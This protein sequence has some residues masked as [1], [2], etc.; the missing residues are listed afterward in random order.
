M[1]NIF[2]SVKLLFAAVG[3]LLL[4][5]PVSAQEWE[6]I[7]PMDTLPVT[8]PWRARDAVLDFSEIRQDPEVPTNNVLYIDDHSDEYRRGSFRYDWRLNTELGV[9]ADEGNEVAGITMVFRAKPTT[10]SIVNHPDSSNWWWYVSIRASGPVGYHTE[11]RAKRDVFELV[12][13]QDQIPLVQGESVYYDIDTNWHTYRVTVIQRDVKIYLD[14]DPTPIIDT[15]TTCVDVGG[16]QLRVGKQDRGTDYGGLFDYFLILEGAIY[17]PGEGPAIPED[18][19][20]GPGS[21]SAVNDVEAAPSISV[22]PNP[23]G[24]TMTLS[25]QQENAGMARVDIYSL[26]GQKLMTPLHQWLTAGKQQFRINTHGL[27]TGVY[28][29]SVNGEYTKFIKGQ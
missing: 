16:N 5:A 9:P 10:E 28:L 24:E 23:V 17:A 19:I 25:F 7:Q 4:V 11:M 21:P 22:Y 29:L 2:T 14:E 8:A 6:N 1:K 15:K 3:L 20:V 12:G 13:C 27:A 26:T 18:I